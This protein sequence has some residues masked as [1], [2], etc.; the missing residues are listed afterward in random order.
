MASASFTA[1]AHSVVL[2]WGWRRRLVSFTAG[3][4]SA[5]A[6]AP[7]D[8]WPM[9]ALTLPVL[10]WLIDG[11]GTG[12]AG[13][14]TAFGAGWWFGFGYFLAGLYWIGMALLVE[15]EQFG[16]LLPFSVIGI[17]AGLAL[18]TG[19]GTALARAIWTRGPTRILAFAVSLT[20]VEW[21]RGYVLTGFPWNSLG[22]ALAAVPAFAQGASLFGLWG[23]TLIA[24]VT[25]SSPATLADPPETSR[26]PWLMPGISLLLLAAL[27]VF[28]MYRLQSHDTKM[29]AGV[30]LRIMQPNLPQDEKFR[31]AAR[32]KVLDLYRSVS[33]RATAPDRSGLRDVTH[34]I[35]PES[36][37]PFF[38]ER[39]ADALAQ[40]ADMLPP[41]VVLVTGAARVGEA[42][43]GSPP[44]VFNSIRTIGDDGAILSTY[45]KLHL[46]PFGEFLPFQS[47]LESLG[48]QQ[49]TRVRGGFTPGVRR[50]AL[51]IPRLPPA[52]PL[53]CY[54]VIFPGSVLTAEGRPAWLLNVTND[55]WFGDTP[56]PHQHFAQARL[57]TIE[58]G[59]PLIRA[60]N[61][62]ISAVVDPLGR[63]VRMLELGTDG[64][65]D[66]GLPQPIE[67]TFYARWRD[68]PT[69]VALLILLIIVVFARRAQRF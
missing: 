31:P 12:S 61:N 46:V 10:V 16:W 21:L 18:F 62:G 27:A 14:R 25:L 60:A 66:S 26:R 28:G 8:L 59:L 49:L 68:T 63:V 2:A 69:F 51:T 35:W 52:S 55:A 57:R 3:A 43:P 19:A 56:G 38:L 64:L 1:A 47:L 6:M 65:I 45:D 50:A 53:I 42:K 24:L 58:E 4:L 5:L 29:V 7:F 11:A 44:P 40:L 32:Q 39:D 36:A 67:A 23:L 15:A 20:I 9:L 30:R 41:G 33:E 17:P 22:Q 48:L 34:L 13:L 37:F 54:E